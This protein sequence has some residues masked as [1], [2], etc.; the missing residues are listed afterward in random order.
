MLLLTKM[1]DGMGRTGLFRKFAIK[2]GIFVMF[3]F[4]LI[5]GALLVYTNRLQLENDIAQNENLTAQTVNTIWRQ[6]E[7]AENMCKTVIQNEGLTSFLERP[8]ENGL[9]LPYYSTT[10]RDFVKVTNGVSDI[11]LRLYLENETIPPG[12]GV[13]YPLEAVGRF[14]EFQRFYEEEEEEVWIRGGHRELWEEDSDGRESYRY[15][16]KIRVGSRLLGVIEAEVPQ[17]VFDIMDELSES[18]LIPLES[19]G[20]YI[21]D[22]SGKDIAAAEAAG[23]VTDERLTYTG[24]LVVS[25]KE[26]PTGPFGVIVVTSRSEV[27]ILNM[28]LGGILILFFSGMLIGFFS[29]NRRTIRDINSC[30]DGME[31]AISNNFAVSDEEAA[32]AEDELLKRRD[33]ITVLTLRIR[34]LLS[35]IRLL[36]DREVQQQTAAKEAQL[37]ALQ[38]QINPHFLYNT[39]EVFSSRMELAGLY[40]ES[41]AISAFCHMLRYNM[42][43]QDLMVTLRDEIQQVKYY[44]A[45]QKIRRI[46]FEID[47]NI[48]EELL[49]ERCIRFLLEPFV[50]NSF[51]YRSPSGR[52]RISILAGRT[53]Q[54]IEVRIGNNGETLGKERVSELNERFQNASPSMETRGEHIGLNNI[55]AR[56]KLF[57]G[58]GYFIHVESEGGY[59]EFSFFIRAEGQQ[60]A[61]K[62]RVI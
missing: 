6:I 17:K 57:Y 18:V 30:L 51:K 32:V 7:L 40:E 50:E 61:G 3:P 27:T 19:D 62:M 35:E 1:E 55:N 28:I 20:Y 42:N 58:D 31:R 23:F 21:Y 41:G 47:F 34:Y 12:F 9:D 37:L 36:L 29:Y 5:A 38:H 49:S 60:E 54:G 22:F 52:L 13:F 53:E 14:P 10:I 11:R 15:F 44:L 33:E 59:T 56:L 16:H 43:T 24:G 39:M 4:I 45:I 25:R 46:P 48:S 2:F 26:M 8:Y